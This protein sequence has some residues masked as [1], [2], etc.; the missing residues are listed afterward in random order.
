MA[1]EVTDSI[2]FALAN[3]VSEISREDALSAGAAVYAIAKM[4]THP[5]SFTSWPM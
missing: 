1:L 2:I 5:A 4:L 3:P